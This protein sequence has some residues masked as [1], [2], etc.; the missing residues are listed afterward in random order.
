MGIY[1]G[2]LDDL[3]HAEDEI[4]PDHRQLPPERRAEGDRDDDSPHGDQQALGVKFR[5][6]SR[7]KNAADHRII[8]APRNTV[9]GAEYKHPGK[10][11]PRGF[12]CFEKSGDKRA[13]QKHQKGRKKTAQQGEPGKPSSIKLPKAEAV[14]S[15]H[16]SHQ[17]AAGAAHARADADHQILHHRHD[18]IGRRGVGSQMA[19]DDGIHGHTSAPG[20]I[21]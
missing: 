16:S 4:H 13:A 12:A 3:V 5:I 1:P 20:H 11:I 21:V 18:G 15:Q 6:A 8:D 17:D 7:R 10:K 9:G 2:E 19:D 14:L